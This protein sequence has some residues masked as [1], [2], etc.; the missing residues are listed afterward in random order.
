MCIKYYT[1]HCSKI[2][3]ESG[4]NGKNPLKMPVFV[5]FVP[6]EGC[7]IG[8]C[9]VNWRSGTA[10]VALSP[11]DWTVLIDVIGVNGY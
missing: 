11:W 10:F 6:V 4:K 5:L 7:H 1:T 8:S 2:K 9:V 3:L